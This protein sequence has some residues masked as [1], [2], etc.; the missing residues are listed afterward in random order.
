MEAAGVATYTELSSV[1]GVTPQ[2]VSRAFKK[3]KIPRSWVKSISEKFNVSPDWLFN[4]K[5]TV[6]DNKDNELASALGDKN[7]IT[8]TMQVARMIESLQG[9]SIEDLSHFLGLEPI[10]ITQAILNGY[11]PDEWVDEL[12]KA[13]NVSKQSI[14]GGLENNKKYPANY[15]QQKNLT[16]HADILDQFARVN[17]DYN[18]LAEETVLNLKPT[19]FKKLFDEFWAEK[20]A[21]RGWLQV[22]TVRRFPE[23]VQWL[24]SKTNVTTRSLTAKDKYTTETQALDQA[25]ASK[26]EQ[27]E[28]EEIARL[29]YQF[30]VMLD[31]AEQEELERG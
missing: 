14:L 13:L 12:T 6:L 10:N 20:E 17:R 2:A 29:E 7:K 26:F 18:K 21:R 3:N 16:E 27:W 9:D 8:A 23:F 30:K 28:K 31:E 19:D 5:Q 4:E 24:N 15:R 11:V 22:E 1:L 25:A